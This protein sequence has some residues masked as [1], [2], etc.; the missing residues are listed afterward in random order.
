MDLLLN[1]QDG[2]ASF[3]ADIFKYPKKP[4]APW[5]RADGLDVFCILPLPG[6]KQEKVTLLTI[7]IVLVLL[8]LYQMCT[9]SQCHTYDEVYDTHDSTKTLKPIL[10]KRYLSITLTV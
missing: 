2:L 3:G 1:S 5:K 10:K 8:P 7:Y 9:P 6:E 4:S